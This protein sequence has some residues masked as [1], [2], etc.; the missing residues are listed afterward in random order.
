MTSGNERH[1]SNLINEK[2]EK[3]QRIR[4]EKSEKADEGEIMSHAEHFIKL[5]KGGELS[6]HVIR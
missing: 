2:P 5:L 4:T 6:N 1:F 3:R